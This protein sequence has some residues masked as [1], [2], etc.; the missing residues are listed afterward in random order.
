[1]QEYQF[2]PKAAIK[3]PST[4]SKCITSGT[5]YLLPT[6]VVGLGGYRIS[7]LIVCPFPAIRALICGFVIYLKML[8]SIS[9]TV[10]HWVVGC[11]VISQLGSMWLEAAVA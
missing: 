7:N 6:N 3:Y 1:M 2:V 9:E 4:S 11:L 8:L 10:Q 5:E